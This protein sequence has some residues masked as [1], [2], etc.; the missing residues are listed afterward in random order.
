MTW[1]WVAV[2]WVLIGAGFLGSVIPALP[3]PPL[4]FLGILLYDWSTGFVTLGSGW[5]TGFALL[6]AAATLLGVLAAGL[7]A[8]RYGASPG[9]A[10][11]ALAGGFLGVLA[12]GP[13]GLAAGPWI[14]ALLGEV[15]S[16]R[17]WTR[18]AVAG[19]GAVLGALLSLIVQLVVGG[20]MVGLFLLKLL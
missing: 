14:G 2:A 17:A 13:L 15:L 20:L 5:L 7:G 18:A 8:R 12:Q 9:G 3:G 10:L 6:A 4:I 11:G 16:G 19:S 1:L